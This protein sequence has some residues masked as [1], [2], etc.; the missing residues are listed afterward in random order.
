MKEDH[1]KTFFNYILIYAWL[2]SLFF[3]SSTSVLVCSY[4]MGWGES[5]TAIQGQLHETQY[6]WGL[7]PGVRTD[8][9]FAFI[10][11]LDMESFT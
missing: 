9:A 5:V 11:W 10:F 8:T 1:A 2:Q 4:L 3:P 7:T 6:F